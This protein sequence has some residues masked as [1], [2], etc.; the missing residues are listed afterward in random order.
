MK[1]LMKS[2]Q[3]S[4]MKAC[5]TFWRSDLMRSVSVTREMSSFARWRTL[6][7]QSLPFASLC[8]K[9]VSFS[10]TPTFDTISSTTCKQLSAV[11]GAPK[12]GN[13]CGVVF[14]TWFFWVIQSAFQVGQEVT[15]EGHYMHAQ[16]G[17]CW[18]F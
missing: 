18:T 11:V 5:R 12:I 1:C 16:E 17:G 7:P 14:K 3:L 4:G 13:A 6:R 2:S 10:M 9:F 8:V 15:D